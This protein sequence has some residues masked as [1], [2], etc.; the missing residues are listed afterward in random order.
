MLSGMWLNRG[1]SSSTT[2]DRML[3]RA[4]PTPDRSVHDCLAGVSSW[5]DPIRRQGERGNDPHQWQE[6][7]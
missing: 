6:Q 4:S 7:L 5:A 2:A 3:R 1:I